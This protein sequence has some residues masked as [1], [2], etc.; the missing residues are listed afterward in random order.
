MDEQVWLAWKLDMGLHVWVRIL[1]VLICVLS[2]RAA[3]ITC[4]RLVHLCSRRTASCH[5]TPLHASPT[6]SA[7][8]RAPVQ[9]ISAWRL[10]HGQLC[11][12]A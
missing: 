9:A 12:R 7:L 5:L 4:M 11:C 8:F 1:H 6:L 2:A 10:S 3:C